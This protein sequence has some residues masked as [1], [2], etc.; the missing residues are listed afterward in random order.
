MITTI[1]TPFTAITPLFLCG[2]AVYAL[3]VGA[4]FATIRVLAKTPR[5]K[6]FTDGVYRISRNP[7]YVS[8]TMIFFGICLVTVNLA[9]FVN[10]AVLVVLQHFMIL[11]EERVCREKYGAT[12]VSYMGKVPRY[13]LL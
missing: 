5:D 12:Y 13:L 8:A 3:G 1:W 10:L 2:T 9:L 11:A 6:P 4:F 7:L